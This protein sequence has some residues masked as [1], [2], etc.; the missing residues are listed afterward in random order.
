MNLVPFLF[1]I[2]SLEYSYSSKF[3]TLLLNCVF[4]SVK[5]VEFLIEKITNPTSS[6]PIKKM[7]TSDVVLV[8]GA[9][10]GVGRRVVNILREKGLP[11]R[12]LV[13]YYVL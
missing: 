10:G 3:V 1:L 9:T 8:A 12:V 11:V 5:F 2:Y 4:S 7:E 6:E 13:F